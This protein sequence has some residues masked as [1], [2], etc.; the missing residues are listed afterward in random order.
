MIPPEDFLMAYLDAYRRGWDQA[1]LADHLGMS[2]VATKSRIS[3]LKKRGVK[4]PPLRGM[5]DPSMRVDVKRFNAIIK[6][7]TQEEDED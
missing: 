5:G 7:F 4:L 2:K 3:H 1:Q 6:Q